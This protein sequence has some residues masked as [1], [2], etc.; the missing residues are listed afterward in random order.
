MTVKG[1]IT[2]GSRN[3][4]FFGRSKCSSLLLRVSNP[5]EAEVNSH[6]TGVAMSIADGDFGVETADSRSGYHAVEYVFDVEPILSGI[7]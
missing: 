7:L 4:P 1:F 2:E 5:E 3:P 6:V